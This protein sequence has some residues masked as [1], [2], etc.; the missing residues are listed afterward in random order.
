MAPELMSEKPYDHRADLWSLGCI[1]YETMAGQPPFCT[2]SFLRLV[3]LIQN[4]NVRWPSFLSADCVSFLQGLLEKDP[5]NRLQWSAILKHPFVC[6]HITILDEPAAR[7]PFTN[8]LS[9][10]QCLAK[11][12]QLNNLTNMATHLKQ[13]PP[14]PLLTAGVLL[15]PAA[16]AGELTTSQD[17]IHAILQSDIE[18]LETDVEDGMSLYAA[19]H[20]NQV[21]PDAS[22]VPIGYNFSDICFVSGNSNLIVTNFNDNFQQMQRPGDVGQ[23]RV[24]QS[25]N[26]ELEKR[27]LSQ[28]LENF[29]VRLG[30]G[31]PTS[32]RSGGDIKTTH[33]D[34]N[35][36][37]VASAAPKIVAEHA[38]SQSCSETS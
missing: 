36:E 26:K 31:R 22:L 11:E 2:T 4:E 37:S 12:R 33:K 6:G 19:N 38:Q 25:R 24:W 34:S 18:N 7:S 10:S 23:S 9:T 29:S 27:K 8:P 21:A 28:N 3:K 13:S 17:S 32:A 16:A 35:K 5:I 20:N 15:T 30:K 14:N 1:I